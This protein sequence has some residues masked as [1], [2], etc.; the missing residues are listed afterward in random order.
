M[1]AE[2]HLQ[3]T[4]LKP[5]LEKAGA[6]YTFNRAEEELQKA[7]D[8]SDYTKQDERLKDAIKLLNITRY[9][10]RE[11]HGQ[12]EGNNSRNDAVQAGEQHGDGS[13]INN[14]SGD[15]KKA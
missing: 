11:R 4:E 3:Q 10:L 6:E 9:K 15:N 13:G 2:C 12:K 8:E 14:K 7:M 5:F 1:L